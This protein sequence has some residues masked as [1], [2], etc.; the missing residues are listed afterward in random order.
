MKCEIL[1]FPSIQIKRKKPS[2]Y[3]IWIPDCVNVVS[4][5]TLSSTAPVYFSCLC[6]CVHAQLCLVL[7]DSIDCNLPG[8]FVHGI[9]QARILERV[10]ISTSRGSS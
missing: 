10:V 4:S 7:G 6:A 2:I 3:N 5:V 8:F 9:I 1:M